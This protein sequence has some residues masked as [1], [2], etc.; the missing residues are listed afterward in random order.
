[1]YVCAMCVCVCVDIHKPVEKASFRPSGGTTYDICLQIPKACAHCPL[2]PIMHARTHTHTHTHTLTHRQ[3]DTLTHTHTHTYIHTH[4][5]HV[6][7][8]INIT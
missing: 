8:I 3:T 2:E 5:I 7:W 4:N 1:M 6:Y